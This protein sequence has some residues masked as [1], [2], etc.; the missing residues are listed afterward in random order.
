[1]T[2]RYR[3]ATRIRQKALRRGL[4]MLSNKVSCD[5]VAEYLA[6]AEQRARRLENV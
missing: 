3:L 1:M 6:R 5:Q 2:L 4:F